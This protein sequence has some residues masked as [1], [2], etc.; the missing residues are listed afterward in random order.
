M[1]SRTFS[2]LIAMVALG[3][4][5]S[6]CSS[7]ANQASN[8]KDAVQKSEDQAGLKN[9]SVDVDGKKGVVTLNGKVQS[10]ADKNRAGQVAQSVS[11]GYVVANQ[12][13]IEPP[14]VE[15][16]ARDVEKNVDAAIE[17][18]FK[19]VLIGNHLDKERIRFHSKNAVLTLEGKVK[20][21]QER[22]EVEKIA[23]EVPKVEQV[24]NKLDVEQRGQ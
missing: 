7:K 11:G 20:D 18:N 8:I 24:V 10:E 16:Q 23:S 13:S 15:S 14:Q 2:S 1:S 4:M 22:A 3:L 17:K 6:G 5:L 19:A 21:M 9:V 12:V